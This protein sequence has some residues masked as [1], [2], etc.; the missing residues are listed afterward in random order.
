MLEKLKQEFTLALPE[1][2]AKLKAK[3]IRK[4]IPDIG[5]LTHEDFIQ[6]AYLRIWENTLQYGK[7]EMAWAMRKG[8][9]GVIDLLRR[10]H[11]QIDRRTYAKDPA[12]IEKF[13]RLTKSQIEDLILT[14]IAI[15]RTR[16]TDKQ[17]RA[18]KLKAK[19]FTLAEIARVTKRS[20]S[21]CDDT[22]RCARKKIRRQ[23][24]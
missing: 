24:A 18:L 22:I 23:L 1:I 5:V 6:E 19:G 12:D 21:T 3:L 4:R 2:Q 15:A 9:D 17:A 11:K 16:L 20:L 13:S 7:F 14:K 10:M 8:W